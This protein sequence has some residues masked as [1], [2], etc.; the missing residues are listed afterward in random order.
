MEHKYGESIDIYHHHVVMPNVKWYIKVDVV[1]WNIIIVQSRTHK[2]ITNTTWHHIYKCIRGK[3]ASSYLISMLSSW[4]FHSYFIFFPT[5]M[6]R[7][8]WG[9]PKCFVPPSYDL[10]LIFER[11]ILLIW[12]SAIKRITCFVL[13]INHRCIF[14]SQI[15]FPTW[16]SH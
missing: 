15:Q 3:L 12:L 6:I 9:F 7:F 2:W 16:A 4:V 13:V 11:Y 1:S 10:N 14:H 8:I 5:P